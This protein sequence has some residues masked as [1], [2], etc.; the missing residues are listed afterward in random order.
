MLSPAQHLQLDVVPEEGDLRDGVVEDGFAQ[1]VG[2]AHVDGGEAGD[3]VE[4][5]EGGEDVVLRLHLGDSS[6]VSGGRG[7]LESLGTSPQSECN[8]A[9]PGVTWNTALVSTRG[10]V[11]W[12]HHRASVYLHC[13]HESNLKELLI[14]QK[15]IIK[16][17]IIIIIIIK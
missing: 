10:I 2:E 12:C 8:T 16:I 11:R 3:D 15:I 5:A 14:N 13:L 7:A 1:P 4:D 9:L 17:I 6:G